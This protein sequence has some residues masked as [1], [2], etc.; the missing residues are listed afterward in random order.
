V[1]PDIICMGEPLVEFNETQPGVF[2]QGFGG[3]TSNCAIAAARQGARVGYLTAVGADAFGERLLAL[4]RGEG[5]GTGHVI[6]DAKH[7]TGH[8]FVTHGADG[9]VFTYHRKGS[10]ASC[11]RAADLPLDY[12]A[13]ARMLHVSAISQAISAAAH[14]AVL[15]AMDTARAAGVQVS[16]DTNLRL[17]LWSLDEAREA[18]H[19][20]LARA[21]IALP[22]YDDAVQLTGLEDPH[23]IV[24]FY[25]DLGPR[26]VALSLGAGGVALA[27]GGRMLRIA[28]HR[29]DAVDATGAGDTFDGAFL[30][31]LAG[32][33]QPADAARHANAA[34]ALSTLGYGAVAP[35]PSREQVAAFLAREGA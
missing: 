15:A 4:W 5:V 2:R 24:A 29:V 22:G 30:A 9:H 13:A 23:D 35:I 17:A 16:Y 6:R 12:I 28:G 8:Y 14:D 20:A 18:I 26:T 19:G 27:A 33:M 11:M 21:D 1:V 25:L 10:A 34:A 3:D 32:G 7:P 31:M